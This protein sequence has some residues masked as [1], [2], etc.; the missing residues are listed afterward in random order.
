MQKQRADLTSK[1]SFLV[2]EAWRGRFCKRRMSAGTM[3]SRQLSVQ[4]IALPTCRIGFSI[5]HMHQAFT[6]TTKQ[7]ARSM[8][9]T[10]HHLLRC[11]ASS[12]LTCLFAMQVATEDSPARL[13]ELLCGHQAVYTCKARGSLA[14]ARLARAVS[15]RRS[16]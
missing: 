7:H 2:E 9:I 12:A 14:A 3:A 13:D 1:R 5:A 11:A 4:W 15:S 8:D 6:S 10:M 16:T